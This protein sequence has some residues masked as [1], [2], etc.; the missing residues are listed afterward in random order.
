MEKHSSNVAQGIRRAEKQRQI[1]AFV[2]ASGHS[3]ERHLCTHFYSEMI[4]L[5]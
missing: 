2:L 3:C 5:A 1:F 4:A